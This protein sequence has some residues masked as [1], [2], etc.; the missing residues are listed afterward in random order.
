MTGCSLLIYLIILRDL[1]KMHWICSSKDNF[2]FRNKHKCFWSWTWWTRLSLKCNDG[3]DLEL[4]FWLNSNFWACLQGSWIE[5]IFHCTV[6]SEILERSW[7]RLTVFVIISCTAE[8]KEMSSAK[9]FGLDCKS[10]GKSFI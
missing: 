8:N 1:F 6:H 7:L 2:G 9:I 4:D 3:Y 10:F 5:F